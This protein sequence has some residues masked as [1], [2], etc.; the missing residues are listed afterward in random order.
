LERYYFVVDS[1]SELNMNGPRRGAIPSSIITSQQAATIAF[2]IDHKDRNRRTF[3]EAPYMF[4]LILRASIDSFSVRSFH[5]LCD[6]EGPTVL[7]IK[8]KGSQRIIGAYNPL[9]W[10]SLAVVL[11]SAFRVMPMKTR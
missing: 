2:W 8:L 3:T 4:N 5:C 1:V 11:Y 10:N 9:D 6:N 7:V